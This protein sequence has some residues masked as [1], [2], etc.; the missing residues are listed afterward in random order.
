MRKK[1]KI[2]SLRRM[3]TRNESILLIF[4]VKRNA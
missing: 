2:D 3:L 1:V 4:S